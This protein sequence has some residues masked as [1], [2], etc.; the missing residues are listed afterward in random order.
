MPCS[1]VHSSLHTKIMKPET[2]QRPVFSILIIGCGLSGLA[3]AL[4]L[5]QAG[6]HV[7]VFER[8]AV[9]QEVRFPNLSMP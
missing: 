7:T 6:H 4:A 2:P 8:S 3:S 1:K 5:S 9:L